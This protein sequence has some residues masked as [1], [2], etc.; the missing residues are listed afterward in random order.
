MPLSAD[1]RSN[2]WTSNEQSHEHQQQQRRQCSVQWPQIR[3]G[4]LQHD[5]AVRVLLRHSVRHLPPGRAL[6][7]QAVPL[8]VPPQVS[9]AL[10]GQLSDQHQPAGAAQG[11]RLQPRH[12]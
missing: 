6:P 8:P 12:R 9:P 11:R 10:A 5:R 7:A 2:E 4:H 3:G 1:G